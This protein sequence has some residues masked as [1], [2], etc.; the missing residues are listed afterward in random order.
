[1]NFWTHFLVG[2]KR[3]RSKNKS[4]EEFLSHSVCYTTY[5]EAQ[6]S[7]L[8]IPCHNSI[9][10][11]YVHIYD[12]V[13]FI[14]H[15]YNI[16]HWICSLKEKWTEWQAIYCSYWWQWWWRW[17]HWCCCCCNTMHKI[18][19]TNQCVQANRARTHRGWESS[20]W[21][22]NRLGWTMKAEAMSCVN[23]VCVCVSVLNRKIVPNG[24]ANRCSLCPVHRTQNPT[25]STALWMYI[26]GMRFTA[27]VF[28]P[29]TLY[30]HI[31]TFSFD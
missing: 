17:C 11:G 25:M 7:Y 8:S 16:A 4:F 19:P 6:Y 27:H 18:F 9:T 21:I 30:C 24:R 1:M 2:P 22:L 29:H 20:D 10:F 3:T 12:C 5:I 28:F 31:I 13:V 14:K 26:H 23:C 15:K